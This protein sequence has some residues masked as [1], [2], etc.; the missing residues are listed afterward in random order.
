[1]QEKFGRNLQD[2][3]KVA[4]GFDADFQI[5]SYL[6]Y[7]GIKFVERFDANAY[8]YITRALDYFDLG[9]RSCEC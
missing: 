7:Q 4:F 5:E 1:M 9:G 2:R 3:D 6:R 8:L